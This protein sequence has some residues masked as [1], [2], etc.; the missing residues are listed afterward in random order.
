VGH[1]VPVAATRTEG[2]RVG[3]DNQAASNSQADRG[4]LKGG[5]RRRRTHRLRT[6]VAAMAAVL[7]FQA[8]YVTPVA[9][10]SAPARALGAAMPH[11]APPVG[12]T[13]ALDPADEVVSVRTESTRT[14]DLGDGRRAVEA[15]P[16]PVFYQP[17]GST[18]WEPIEL[19]FTTTDNGTKASVTKS[20][21][22][23]TVGEQA[24]GF[25]ALEHKGHR[26]ALRPIPVTAGGPS[27]EGAKLEGKV[28]AG[29]APGLAA[30]PQPVELVDAAVTEGLDAPVTAG[31]PTTIK[32]RA[33]L[34]G[35]LPGV[36]L[37]VFVHAYGTSNFLVLAERPTET[38]W[39]FA[40][41]AKGLTL[42]PGRDGA[43]EF[44]DEAGKA[45]AT[46]QA[47]YA[48]DSTPDEHAGGGRTTTSAWYTLSAL[49]SQQLV[50]VSVDPAWLADAVYPVY[51]DPSVTV[52]NDGAT[53][54]GDTHVNQGNPTYNYANYKRPDAPGYY[55]MWLGESPTDSTYWNWDF[56]RFDLGAYNGSVVESAT[57]EVYP[58]HQYYNAPTTSRVYLRRVTETWT[59]AITWNT[60][61]DVTST[62]M[63]SGDCVE[64][65]RCAFD[66][67]AIARDWRDGDTADFG[68]R[69]DEVDSTGTRKGPTFWKR[70]I[71]GE[72]STTARPR[73][74]L[75]Y[76]TPVS[77]VSPDGGATARTAGRTLSWATEQ[78]WGQDMYRVDVSTSSTFATTLVT[79]GDVTSST[80]REWA[81][82]TTTALTAGTTYYW[83]VKARRTT[84]R[85]PTPTT[86]W[87]LPASGSFVWDPGADLGMQSQH[88][89]ESFDLGAGDSLAVNVATGNLVLSHPIVDLPIRGG[90]LPLALTYN[91]YDASS[92]GLGAG[93]RLNLQR[94]LA[95]ATN[96]DATFTDADG[97]RHVFTFAGG[98]YTAPK[99]RYATLTKTAGSPNVY[100]LTYR[101]RSVDVFH[102]L[103]TNAAYL[104]QSKDR[105][106]NTVTFA[107]SGTTLTGAT[108]PAG[109]AI[110]F[111][112]AADRLTIRDWAVV[113]ADHA[114]LASGTPN[115]THQ[116]FLVGGTVSGWAD[117]YAP[118][119][120][121]AC[122]STS[123]TVCLGYTGGLLASIAKTQTYET[124][125]SGVLGT[126]T[127]TISTG[128]TFAATQVAA[129]KDAEQVAAGGT[130]ITFTRAAPALVEVVRP[131]TPASTTRYV[132]AAAT[133]P[134]AR[135]VGVKRLLGAS[136]WIEERTTYDTT[137]P[138]E[139]A[140]VTQNYVD[141]TPSDAAP[142]EDRETKYT[143]V[144]NSMGLVAEVR[145]L[146]TAPTP[147]TATYRTTSYTYNANSDV[148]QTIAGQS[149]A[150]PLHPAFT[151]RSCY[152]ASCTT[153]GSGLVLLKTINNY[154]DGTAGNGAA[155]VEDVTVTYQADAYGQRI[156]ETRANYTAAGVLLDQAAT[157]WT[158]NNLGN[159]TA[160]IRNYASGTVTNPGD[161]INPSAS[162]GAR[163]DLTTTFGYDTAGNRT[164]TADPRRAIE[165]AKGT[166]LGADDFISRATFDALGQQLTDKTPTTPGVSITQKTATTAYD[167]LG[168][169]LEATDFGGVVTASEFDRTG[170]PTRTFEDSDGIGTAAAAVTSV[171]T[172]DAAGRA[173]TAKDRRQADPG[174]TLGATA[175]T[176][177]E[178][179]RTLTVNEASGSAP[180]IESDTTTSYDDLD[181]V[182][183]ETVGGVQTTTSTYDLGGR[184]LRTDDE[185]ACTKRAFD[186]QDRE[187]EVIEGLSSG[188]CAGTGTL[189]TTITLDAIG[190]VATQSTSVAGGSAETQTATY[191]SSGPRTTES[192]IGQSTVSSTFDVNPLDEVIAEVRS[193]GSTTKT[194]YDPAGNPTDVCYWRP[195]STVGACLPADTSSASWPNPP[196]QARTADYDARNGRTTLIT[197]LGTGSMVSL[198][199]YDP[200]HGYQ[201]SAVYLPT[202]GGREVQDLYAYDAQHRVTTITHQLCVLSSGHAC[203]ATTSM[204]SS[205]YAYDADSN[206]TSVTESSTGGTTTTRTYCYD[207]LDRLTASR[208]T[209]SCATSPDETYTYDDAGNRLTAATSGSTRSFVHGT[210]GQLDT[211]TSP[212]C[213][214]SYD[215]AGRTS[216][217]VD[218]GVA[219]TFAY[220][221][222]GR[223]VSACA[224]TTCTGSGFNRIDYRYDATGRRVTITTTTAG[225][226]VTTTELRYAGTSVAQESVAG[227]ATRTYSSDE[228]GRIVLVCDPD[229]GTGTVYLATW[230]GHGDATAL[231]RRNA[232]GTLTLANSYTYSTWG[233]P[234]TTTH[235]GFADLGF[236]YLYVG[237]AEVQWDNAFGLGLHYMHARHYSPSLGRFLQPDPSAAETNLYAYAGNSPVTK[238]DPSGRIA[239]LAI[240]VAVVRVAMV[241]A[242]II[243]AAAQRVGP[244][245]A[246]AAQRV[247]PWAT[248]WGDWLA[249][250]WQALRDWTTQGVRLWN[251]SAVFGQ[252]VGTALTKFDPNHRFPDIIDNYARFAR[253]F[254]LPGGGRL[255]QV[256]GWLNGKA[257][258]FEWIVNAGGYVTHRYF[259]QGGRINGIPIKP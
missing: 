246:A 250:R 180:D 59:E 248:R 189:T 210:D 55:E 213:S 162:T 238:V 223:V 224:G 220:D 58:Y 44:V 255:Y 33:D 139:P 121:A 166:S 114:V 13:P 134:Y 168:N 208:A 200:D 46:M 133:D 169:V 157:G 198:A 68:V 105:F 239:F 98:T 183:T 1:R 9:A 28:P 130:G 215:T 30:K 242:P 230:N 155:N 193:D 104:K 108:D 123:H 5:T 145:E 161:D 25:V 196:M 159:Q 119:A 251:G 86:M 96:G 170:H 8:A 102:E 125:A 253:Q 150:D 73:I 144:A 20:P 111:T 48:V 235:N 47:P 195:S 45:F 257:G 221:G 164:S 24:D 203:S 184:M 81:I 226:T 236:R 176:Y 247:G 143:Y 3:R 75:I 259:V 214:V 118:S 124:V 181:R 120:S 249:A 153:T 197:R 146:L 17:A 160:E 40:V 163:T 84:S 99:T 136:T 72:H 60:Q 10:A 152:D 18:D 211:G 174:S 233:T 37:R 258:R 35:V 52:Y 11:A 7:V 71:S 16:D 234:T 69:L 194:N 54:Y 252:R 241:V 254:H 93:W 185:F 115:R 165:A 64:A 92:V 23:V 127:R 204:G 175:F 63:R 100:T 53:T 4:T 209:S 129:V 149:P 179:G 67:T 151:S 243:V 171:T 167:E 116:I 192:T 212:S 182:V 15:F 56:L 219:W 76:R 205:S 218:N 89:F 34:P 101:D 49:G 32:Q 107:Y 65:E 135:I 50:T 26:I 22:P 110:Q 117:A 126:A 38:S 91:S 199:T 103:A 19:G 222:A 83:R 137:Y 177:D 80:A 228:M 90:S 227:T 178:I 237:S 147:S 190:R 142:D 42:V 131:G 95:I 74:T 61:P 62:G 77:V 36:G 217:L 186:W 187:T 141:G 128:V 57:L 113:N 216:T 225:G 109:R 256:E 122:P 12:T 29:S 188:T 2:T 140:T 138:V 172:Y 43:L 240:I 94:G 87:S 78:G 206:R 66:I 229:C 148:T 132:L 201:V 158:Y 51:V 88:T 231:W 202:A 39:T 207:A 27:G 41:K 191:S 154:V 244:A 112:W 82:P 156:R 245:V 31:D 21:V 232:D 70:V 106:G 6:T 173:L 79:S 97:S 85:T 14:Y